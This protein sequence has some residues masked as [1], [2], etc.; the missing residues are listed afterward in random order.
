MSQ[1]T[2]PLGADPTALREQLFDFWTRKELEALRAVA[3]K[4][5]SDFQT[6]LEDLLCVLEGCPGRQKGKATTMGHSIL[7]EFERWRR[8]HPKVTLQAVP[9]VSKLGLQRRALILLTDAQP[10]FMDPLIDIY[11]L[12]SLDRSTLRLHIIRLQALNCYREAALLTM[13]L[14]LQNELDMEEMCVPLILQDKL[15]MAESFVSGHPK[16][17]EHMV[18]LLDSW[19]HPD[20]SIAQLCRQ[21]PRLSLSKHQ[22]D[23]IQ[24]KMLSK[25]VFRLMEKFNIDPGLCPNSVYKRKS[26]SMRFLMYKRFVE[27]GMSEE[28][29]SDHVQS[30][31]A[32][33]PELQIQ[34]VEL[35]VKYG[36]MVSAAQ[37]SL[38]YGLPKDRL[39][40][41]VW[42]TQESLPPSLREVSKG[43]SAESWDPPQA[44]RDRFYQLP[45]TRDHVHFLETLEGLQLCRETVLQPGC[46]VGVDMEWR[47]GFGAVS[48]Q[49]RV[50][51]IQLAVPGQVFLLDLCAHGFSQHNITVTFIRSLFSAPTVLKLGYGMAGDLKCLL[52]TWSQFSEEPLKME[53]VL[54]LLNVH[55]QM[56]RSAS[57]RGGSGGPRG[58]LVGEGPSEKGLSLLVQQVLGK[59]LDKMEQ[60]S[61]WERRPL[62]TSQLRYAA[63]DAYCLLDVY[64]ALSCDP[65]C[66]GL[67][68]DLC[69]ISSLQT[70]KSKAEKKS[71]EE[72]KKQA[73]ARRESAP[74]PTSTL[75]PE[76]TP[77]PGEESQ[78]PLPPP[79]A[80]QQLRVVCDNMLQGLGRYLR[81]LGVDVVLLENT[82]DHR[83]AAQLAQEDGRV[84][85]TCGQPYQTLKSQVGEG[86]CIALDCSEKARDQAVR[87]L[88]HFNVQPTQSDIFSRCQVCNSDQYLKMPREDM[89][90]LLKER[91]FLQQ[92]Q[93]APVPPEGET[94]DD[95][96]DPLT[97]PTLS[98]P[99][100][101]VPFLAPGV[102]RY[103]PH[104]RWAPLSDLDSST[105][106]FP[107]G[108][109]LQLHTVPPG[110]LPRIP[111][112]FICTGCG[113]VFWEGSHFSRVLSQF[114]EVLCIT[115]DTEDT[116]SSST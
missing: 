2:Q 14:E 100:V 76:R 52:A 28:N 94:L 77:Q 26:D 73:R 12:G 111:F 113:K 102:P 64:S 85:L 91:G 24:P 50:A 69:S 31:V 109:V 107:R 112:F 22:T 33:D 13:K 68:Q 46:I 60:L 57:S 65:A 4:G 86:R 17:E 7:M 87:V 44:H 11:Q 45:I 43:C 39:P 67:P 38:R 5:F 110:L 93:Q 82:D 79:M 49:Q 58:V 90:R 98:T 32:D 53:G 89:T 114:Q 81:C 8:T 96:L 15:P 70:E 97:L 18:T 48:P 10:S 16:L 101:P 9:E 99:P 75:G 84:I 6:P 21:F 92:Q 88:K 36:G 103:S 108:A 35:M 55:Q 47:A 115:E 95:S 19:C 56:Q 61:N 80:P 29:W 37:W 78:S 106:T 83:V 30:T 27:K 105:L 20:F 54:D 71:K 42:D 40:F 1:A 66:F 3:F 25:Q 23:Q 41:G 51:L 116:P 72:K 104:C 74:A 62:R 63:V 59:P 34:L